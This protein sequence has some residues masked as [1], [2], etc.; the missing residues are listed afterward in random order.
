MN[1]N[2]GSIQFY[3]LHKIPDMREQQSFK[4][5][6]IELTSSLCVSSNQRIVDHYREKE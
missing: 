4:L 6:I 1:R 2:A 3:V 5:E